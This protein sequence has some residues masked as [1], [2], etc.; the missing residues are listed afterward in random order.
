MQ[1]I[2]YASQSLQA[3]HGIIVQDTECE[4][5]DQRVPCIDDITGEELLLSAVC[6]AR[7]Q[8]RTYLRHLG[9][10]EKVAE[11]EAIV[12]YQVTPVDTKWM[13]TKKHSRISPCK[14]GHD[15][16]QENSKVE[17]DPTRLR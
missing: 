14:P 8:E 4:E 1:K 16:W 6:H 13:D 3:S 12:K 17:I 7:Q 5:E 10:Y 2:H 11:R 9:V 15:S